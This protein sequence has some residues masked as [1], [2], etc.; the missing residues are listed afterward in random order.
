MMIAFAGHRGR[1]GV[2]RRLC[3]ASVIGCAVAAT[4]W[5]Q[6]PGNVHDYALPASSLAQ[7]I[8]AIGQS[9]DVQ[10]IYDAALLKGKTA[11]PISGHFT[12]GQ[13]LDK[14][15]AGSGLT[16]EL[17]NSGHTV[18]IRK[19]PPSPQKNSPT[20][21]SNA[22][23]RSK[24]KAEP[25][26]L[27]EVAVT[28]TRIPGAPPAS[29]V[30]EISQTRMI[31]A[32]Q[33]NLGEVIRDIPQNFS[34]G[35]NPGIGAEAPGSAEIANQNITGGSALDLRGLGPDATLTLLNGN[36]LSYD[37][38][39]QAVDISQIPLAAVDRIEIVA[40]G[41]SAIYGSDA[42]AGVANV[43]LK[44]D[45]SGLS[46]TARLGKATSGGDF[47]QQYSIVGGNKWSGGGFLAALD[48][49]TDTG[50]TGQQ[51][52]YTNYLP[53]P[54]SILPT[55]NV[56]SGIFSGHQKLSDYATFKVDA[57]YTER[58]SDRSTNQLGTIYGGH[59]S[60]NK[61]MVSPTLTFHLPKTWTAS[62]KGTYGKDRSVLDVPVYTTVNG[63]LIGESK[64][65]YCN[66]VKAWEV[67]AEGPLFNLPGGDANAAFGGGYRSNTFS[68]YSLI[69]PQKP[70]GGDEHSYYVFGELYLPVISPNLNIPMINQLSFSAAIRREDYNDFG[71]ITTPKVGIIYAPTAD[72]DLKASWGKSFKIPT[73]LQEYESQVVYLWPA[74]TVGGVDY[75][76][77]ATAL[78]SYG[79]N[80]DLRPERAT[81]WTATLGLHPR[82]LPGLQVELG[83]FNIN[84]KDRVAQGIINFRSA[85]AEPAYKQFVNLKPTQEQMTDLIKNATR[86]LNYSGAT[87]DHN[88]VIAI[89]NDLY[90]NVA[91]QKIHGVDISASYDFEFMNSSLRFSG[92]ASWLESKQQTSAM[93]PVIDLAGTVYNPPHWRSRM[94]ATWDRDKL[95]MSAFYTFLGGITNNTTAPSENG[96][97]MKTVDITGIWHVS[98]DVDLSAS[99]RNLTNQRPP[100]LTPFSS[101][102]LN[103]DSTNY[104]AIGRFVSVAITKRW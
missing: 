99:I 9:N 76:G 94:G 73:L 90:V 89:L 63:S 29:P 48:S 20:A 21:S 31:Q 28:G 42:V 40:D 98:N 97:S 93:V 43:I 74:A 35:Q 102:Y 51:R 47:Q 71:G 86:F 16:Y 75:P 15:L 80:P 38:Y 6:A 88:T 3:L 54:Y 66:S 4:A 13:A 104:S 41:A 87:Y 22:A 46:A 91:A 45:Y 82:A 65:C 36:R 92:D 81:T 100:Y 61:Y 79:G 44:P 8:N 52:D 34:G 60:T 5:A 23:A 77:T 58:S 56:L 49:E 10:V 78:M 37:G 24:E 103:Y 7:S 85:L 2:L 17:V 27:S 11:A 101:I 96:T 57:V 30:I 55:N 83:Y 64:Y 50:I 72:F 67:D 18:V 68:T 32:G 12:L 25:T 95:T 39:G 1:N 14:A 19:A 84:Y 59:F 53:T 69:G 70:Q 62:V 26:I 33:T